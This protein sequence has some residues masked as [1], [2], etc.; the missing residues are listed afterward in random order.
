M[1][2]RLSIERVVHGCLVPVTLN[3]EDRMERLFHVYASLD[4]MGI[5]YVG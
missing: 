4:D 2:D 3:C 5:V 1:D